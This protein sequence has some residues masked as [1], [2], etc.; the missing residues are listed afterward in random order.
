[1]SVEALIQS[2]NLVKKYGDFQAKSIITRETIPIHN[3]KRKRLS[4]KT[5]I[6]VY[7]M[8]KEKN[9]GG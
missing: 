9:H 6:E 1:M 7:G 5:M 4:T 8:I 3:W 2:N